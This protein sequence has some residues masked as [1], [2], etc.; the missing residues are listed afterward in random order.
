LP[1]GVKFTPGGPGVKLR[2]TLSGPNP[3]IASYNHSAV[4][5][6]NLTSSLVRFEKKKYF[7]LLW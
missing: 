1:L 5:I 6:F 7:P 3:M 4:K 2:M